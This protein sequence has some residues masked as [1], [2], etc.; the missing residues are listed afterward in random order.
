MKRIVAVFVVFG[1][2]IMTG[3]FFDQAP[4]RAEAGGGRLLPPCQDVNGDGSSN[5]TDAVFLL[6][7]LFRGGPAPTCPSMGGRPVGLPDTG[8]TLC[9]AFDESQF[10][11]V[12]VACDD[13]ACSGQDGAYATGCSPSGRFVDNGDGTVTDTCTGLEWQQDTADVNGDGDSTVEDFLPWCGA[14]AYC[15]DLNFA[16]HDDWRL[17]N[18]REL[19]SIVDFGRFAPAIDPVFGAFSDYY[20]SS[21]TF[22]IDNGS[23]WSVFFEYGSD[24]A[25]VSFGVGGSSS[26]Y[27]RAVRG[28]L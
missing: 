2:G 6:N 14:L 15:E 12:P 17:P 21:T 1:L 18:I 27:V 3:W 11:T 26:L 7:W 25:L 24:G 20:W 4:P 19:Q 10:S 5:L 13:A 28:G 22:A 9:Y 23:A 8:Q 16:G